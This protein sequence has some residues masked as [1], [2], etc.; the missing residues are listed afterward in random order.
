MCGDGLKTGNESCEDNNT[1]SGDG[2]SE[3]CTVE[4]GYNCTGGSG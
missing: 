3:N 2:C 1:K 4:F